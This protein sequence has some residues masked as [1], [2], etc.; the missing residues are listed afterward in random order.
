MGQTLIQIAGRHNIRIDSFQ[1]TGKSGFRKYVELKART[2]DSGEAYYALIVDSRGDE[3]VKSDI[4]NRYSSLV[5]QGFELVIGIRDVYPVSRADLPKLRLHLYDYVK[6]KPLRVILVLAVMEVETWFIAECNHFVKIDGSLTEEVIQQGVG[7]NPCVDNI[8]LRD[9]PASDL[10]AIYQLA[11]KRYDKRKANALRTINNL[12]W[13][14]I[15]INVS[16]RTPSLL[17]L[18]NAID[19]FLTPIAATQGEVEEDA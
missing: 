19:T 7:F 12:D 15:Y 3:S 16:M 2:K 5:A 10:H 4:L 1:A 13:E 11:S 8:E 14:N 9:N 17:S 18:I 6:T